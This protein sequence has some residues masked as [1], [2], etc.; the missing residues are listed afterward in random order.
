MADSTTTGSAIVSTMPGGLQKG[1]IGAAGAANQDTQFT[2][3][4]LIVFGNPDEVITSSVGSQIIFDIENQ[5]IYMTDL[6]GGSEWTRLR[7]V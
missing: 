3:N 1:C 7:T 5:D 4:I 2:E 6:K